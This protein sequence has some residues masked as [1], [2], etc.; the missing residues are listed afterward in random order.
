MGFIINPFRFAASVDTWIDNFSSDLGWLIQDSD[1]VV[2]SGGKLNCDV[3]HNT[4]NDSASYDVSAEFGENID[5][6]LFYMDFQADTTGSGSGGTSIS[7]F[8]LGDS[9]SATQDN[10]N[11]DAI[12]FTWRYRP[13]S[14]R[15]DIF[16]GSADG[17]SVPRTNGTEF[18]ATMSGQTWHYRI[19]RQSAT[20]CDFI[21]YSDAWSNVQET[22]SETISASIINLAFIRWDKNTSTFAASPI[23]SDISIVKVFN[24]QSP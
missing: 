5:D 11:Q 3:V 23:A 6:T 2:I 22:E 20:A 1:Q 12:H 9:S 14:G 4:S 10:V 24:G 18:A 16:P 8:G 15:D 13:A 7:C 17:K 19:E 21:L